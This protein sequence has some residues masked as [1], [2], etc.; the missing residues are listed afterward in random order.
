M[1]APAYAVLFSGVHHPLAVDLQLGHV[2]NDAGRWHLVEGFPHQLLFEGGYR[3]GSRHPVYMTER[4]SGC[5]F[6]VNI[7]CS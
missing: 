7:N 1:G 4:V 6:V 5:D 2:Q 3:R